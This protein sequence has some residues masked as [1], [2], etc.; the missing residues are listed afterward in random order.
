MKKEEILELARNFKFEENTLIEREKGRIE[1]VNRFPLESL[2]KMKINEYI[3]R[4]NKNTFAYWL[5]FKDIIC[6]I[7]GG[8]SQKFYIYQN[9]NDDYVKGKGKSVKIINRENIDMEFKI[10]IERIVNVIKCV[11]EDR[12]NDI[13]NIDVPIWNLVL[14]KIL[15]IYFPDKFFDIA[16]SAWIVEIA[17]IF[18][19]EEITTVNSQNVVALNYYLFKELKNINVFKDWNYLKF[20]GFFSNIFSNSKENYWAGGYTYDEKNMS[21]KFIEK[22]VF[23]VGFFNEDLSDLIGEKEIL[24]EYFTGKN[25]QKK[26]KESITRLLEV[27]KGEKI[28]LKS[29][30]TKKINGKSTSI[31]KV[32]AIG[33]F[34]EDGNI[35]YS[36]DEELIH[37]VP[38][39]WYDKNEREIEGYGGYRSTLQNIKSN[40]SIKKIF[41]YNNESDNENGIIPNSEIIKEENKSK[42]LILYGPPGTGKTYQTIRK[43]LE[44]IDYEA[45]KTIFDFREKEVEKFNELIEKNQIS[46]CTFHQSYG[47]EDFVEGLKSDGNGNFVPQDSILKVISY[48]ALFSALI[49]KPIISQ[50]LTSEERYKIKKQS[51]IDNLFRADLF[52]FKLSDHYLIVID[53]INRGNISKIFGELITLLEPDKRFGEENTI[54]VN[55]PYSKEKF[56]IPK[57][58]HIIATMNTADRS[59]ALMDYALRRR[60]EFLEINSDASLLEPVDEIDLE[61]MLIIINRRIEFLYDKDHTIGH[62]YFMKAEKL[63]DVV[64]VIN[65]GIIPLLQEYFYND[66]EKIGLVLGGIG[67]N[68]NDKY[69]VYKKEILASELFNFDESVVELQNKTQYFIK[70]VITDIELRS[71]Y[72]K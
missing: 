43:A 19:M 16:S 8:S 10:L 61:Q 11:E 64:D 34:T 33:E 28:V 58:L 17:K 32:V 70:Q 15:I 54:I 69:I 39:N 44:V 48:N 12:I 20:G 55:L 1:F 67:K 31:L 51:V 46:F 47:Y 59:I 50:D 23:G 52:N 4:G 36:Y 18:K 66:L 7:K 42:N 63:S 24:D 53:E 9:T 21:K 72:E 38:V 22:G 45:Y 25:L 49:K 6:S 5:E 60:F 68:S 27:N 56:S 14:L 26:E 13:T 65:K 30:Y 37:T 57:N 35:G 71:I 62:A 41:F 2:I 29:S 40:E 3:E